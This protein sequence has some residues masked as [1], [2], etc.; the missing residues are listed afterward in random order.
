MKG[1]CREYRP[2]RWRIRVWHKGER[3]ETRRTKRGEILEGQIQAHKTWVQITQEIEDK[4]FD[5]AEWGTDK[6]FLLKNAF[7]IFQDAKQCGPEWK[8][9]RG[10]DFRTHV[11]PEIGN[12]D[13]REVRAVH[14]NELHGKLIKKGLSEKTIKNVL[15]LLK[16]VFKFHL[17]TN[18]GFPKVDV[19]EKEI[20]WLTLEEQEI[21]MGYL[22]EEDLPIFRFMQITM[23]RAGEAS[24]LQREDVDWQHGIVMIRRSMGLKRRVIPYTKNKKVRLIPIS[25][26]GEWTHI[27]R[28]LEVTPFI[29]SRHGQPYHR[30][31]LERAW[32]PA[33]IKAREEHG[34]KIIHVKNAFRHSG[35]SQLINAGV[36][37]KDVSTMLGHSDTRITEK[38]YAH[39]QPETAWRHRG[40]I[41]ELKKVE[42]K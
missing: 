26:F 1:S 19:P 32:M 22:E 8:Y 7:S 40:T 15:A 35:A 4:I 33:N 30:Q 37:L 28:P 27:L 14:L 34:V 31:R 12:M 17:I 39:I 25:A 36:S 41:T 20:E 29:F 3:F 10:I 18:P 38:I 21:V 2:G 16:S 9:H 11:E 23:C 13:I 6:P 24:A 42:G 5:P